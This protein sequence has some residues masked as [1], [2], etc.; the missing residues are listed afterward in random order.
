MRIRILRYIRVCVRLF[1]QITLE[2][3]HIIVD[4]PPI[5]G[6]EVEDK[7][8]EFPFEAVI[9]CEIIEE[10]GDCIVIDT[11]CPDFIES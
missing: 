1:L 7:E 11:E 5:F 2:K 4:K 3:K 10:I 6:F 8:Y 9:G